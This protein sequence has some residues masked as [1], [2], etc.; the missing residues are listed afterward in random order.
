[1]RRP[2]CRRAQVADAAPRSPTRPAPLGSTAG[3]VDVAEGTRQVTEA[4]DA[5]V[6]P[7]DVGRMEMPKSHRRPMVPMSRRRVVAYGQWPSPVSAAVVAT[8]RVSLSGL[9]VAAGRCWWSESRPG[10]GGRQVVV[11]AALAP[12]GEPVLGPAGDAA[13]GAVDAVPSTMDLRSR[14][15]EYGG[16]SFA[17]LASGDLVVVDAG[18]GGLWLV[19]TGF[20]PGPSAGPDFDAGPGPGPDFDAG[21]GAGTGFGPGE[22]L[23]RLTPVAPA[24]ERHRYGDVAAVGDG[25]WVVALR[26]RFLPE[27]PDRRAAGST[28]STRHGAGTT[29]PERSSPRAVAARCVAVDEIVAVPLWRGGDPVVLAAGHD[30]FASPRPSPDGRQLAYVRWD[31][32]QM[33]WDGSELVVV[34]LDLPAAPAPGD[35]PARTPGTITT[36]G[37]AGA[38]SP[39][40]TA[41]AISPSGT[42]GPTG[43]AGAIGTPRPGGSG[44]QTEVEERERTPEVVAGGP[45]ESVGQ[46]LWV[47]QDLWF[48]CDREDFWQPWRRRG[49]GP[50]ARMSD[51]PADCHTPDWALGQRTMAALPDGTM[52][53][54]LRQEGRDQIAVL[55]PT[56]G[57][58]RRLEQPWVQISALTASGD[59]IVLIGA[60]DDHPSAVATVALGGGSEW[61][62]RPTQAPLDRRSVSVATPVRFPTRAGVDAQMLVYR[63]TSRLV[64]GPSDSRPPLLVLCHGGPTGA[65]DP[66][67]DPQIQFWTSRGF[68]VAAVDYRGSSGYGRAFRQMLRGRWGEADAQD[69]ASAARYLVSADAVDP[70]RLAVRGSSSGGLTALRAASTDGPF[71]AA[72]V[73]YGVTDLRTLA[74]G[75]HKFEERYLDALV[76]P[77]PEAADRYMERSPALHPEDVGAAVLLLHGDQD[78]VV[79]P[80]QSAQMAEALR[81][82]GTYV[83]H[84]VFPGEG[85]GFRR[86]ETI[87]AAVETELRFLTDVLELR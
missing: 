80:E 23:R 54:R 75:T 12:W 76:G 72:I 73:A 68:M 81:G 34:G 32:P 83:V 74:T 4:H 70:G 27:E 71:A 33:P 49:R 29:S 11:C 7:A 36:S 60:T 28:S 61:L 46:P 24:G 35:A 85:H 48:M 78:S 9:Q 87:E 6:E 45:E 15:H 69:V 31:H 25:R 65:C 59:T 17:A 40:G 63:P 26:E 53:L 21:S 58:L 18:D 30:F 38:I 1:M 56:S 64:A 86:A 44:Q 19:P 77:W 84:Q 67:L 10:E 13:V 57:G 20:G 79:P 55:D 42:A 62:H 47:G 22:G 66:G 43:N 3:S 41:G 2:R 5:F 51:V 14:V 52:V 37:T 50:A 16:G 82:A 39:A 8:G